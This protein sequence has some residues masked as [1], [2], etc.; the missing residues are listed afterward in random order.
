M[1][2]IIPS[3]I[4]ELMDQF[5]WGDALNNEDT[6]ELFAYMISTDLAWELQG[7]YGR[8]AQAMINNGFI[9]VNGEILWKEEDNA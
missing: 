7:S 2:A 4:L 5:E 3:R 8:V 9:S 6:L 1:A